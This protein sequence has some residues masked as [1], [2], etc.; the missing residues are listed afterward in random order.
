MNTVKNGIL[1]VYAAIQF[2]AWFALTIWVGKWFLFNLLSVGQD[3]PENWFLLLV[4]YFIWTN[5]L[6]IEAHK[7]S[8]N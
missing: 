4:S 5:Y 6:I 8:R 2:P 1:V 3:M 7:A